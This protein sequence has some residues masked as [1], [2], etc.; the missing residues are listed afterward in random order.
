MDQMLQ[1]LFDGAREIGEGTIF[2]IGFSHILLPVQ[3]IGTYM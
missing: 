2:F 1:K 3:V